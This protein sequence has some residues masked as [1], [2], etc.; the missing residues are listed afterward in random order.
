MLLPIAELVC[1]GASWW[2]APHGGA[3]S[4]CWCCWC[5]SPRHRHQP[6]SRAHARLPLF[7]P[8]PLRANRREDAGAQRRAGGDG[9]GWCCGS[10]RARLRRGAPRHGCGADGSMWRVLALVNSAVSAALLVALVHVL[11]QNGRILLRL[12]AAEARLGMADDPSPEPSGLPVGEVAPN[13]SL[14]NLDDSTVTLDAVAEAGKRI[15]LVFSEPSCGACDEVLP[16][17]ARWQRVMGRSRINAGHQSRHCRT[18][19][20]Q[21]REIRLGHRA[22]AAR[23]G[24]GQRVWG[25]RYTKRRAHRQREDRQPAGGRAGRDSQPGRRRDPRRSRPPSS[26]DSPARPE[27]HAHRSLTANGP[28]AGVA[29]LEP[30]LAATAR[31]C[32]RK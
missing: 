15:V 12:D 2:A 3:H 29:V 10:G 5:S 4:A 32:F 31:S 19:P 21:A 17:V 24:D 11:R 27:W 16:D 13:F 7:R 9:R 23:S 28:A 1:A 14:P 20:Q 22:A 26:G 25:R 8:A 6:G 30:E 18:E